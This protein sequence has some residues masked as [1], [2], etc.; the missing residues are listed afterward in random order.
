MLRSCEKGSTNPVDHAFSFSLIFLLFISLV[1]CP[2]TA[3]IGRVIL[4]LKSFALRFKDIDGL[5]MFAVMGKGSSRDTGVKRG[6]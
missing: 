5:G 6:E 1:A 4:Q 3:V 2:G